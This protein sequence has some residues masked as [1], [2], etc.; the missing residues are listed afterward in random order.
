MAGGAM[1]LSELFHKYGSDKDTDHCYAPVYERL[2]NLKRP[3]VKNVLEIG[4][5]KGG[6]LR[7]WRDW[8]PNAAIWGVDNDRAALFSEDRIR[9]ILG[10]QRE[11]LASVVGDSVRYDL[12]IDD[13][14]HIGEDQLRS[15]E[16]LF[17]LLNVGGDYFIEDVGYA[18]DDGAGPD[19]WMI[20]DKA[21]KIAEGNGGVVS[22]YDM[23]P[24]R[25]KHDD[26]IIHAHAGPERERRKWVTC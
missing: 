6:S 25:G 1:S 3:F 10:D 2:L 18:T 4:V 16:N 13:G 22:F 17:H 11:D 23:R 26:F 20:V 15:L 5:F 7:A 21:R 19:Q 9:C 8:F 24:F 14:S 12:I